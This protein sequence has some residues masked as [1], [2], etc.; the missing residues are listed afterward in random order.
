MIEGL[1]PAQIMPVGRM[2]FSVRGMFCASCAM[3]VQHVIERQPGVKDCT[4]N[5]TSGAALVHW[6]PEEFDLYQLFAR[7]KQL[8][9]EMA[10][11]VDGNEVEQRLQA[12]ANRLQLQLILAG[13]FGMWSM[14][15]TWLLYWDVQGLVGINPLWIGLGAVLFS[16][17]VVLY[18]GLDLYKA[19]WKT[20][21]AG[22]P[23]MDFLVSVGVWGSLLL[24]IWNLWRGH[25]IVYVDAATM[26][27]TFLLLGRLIEIYARKNNLLGIDALRQL[28]PETATLIH[29]GQANQTVPLNEVQVGQL[30]YVQA[31]ERIPVDG[32]VH[33]GQS[34]IDNS[35]LTGES[36]PV[37]VQ[38]G[39]TVYAGM[40]NVLSPLVVRVEQPQ[41]QR[42][43]DTLGLRM[44]ELF[45]AKS[46]MSDAVEA[47]V[48]VLLPAVF[49]VAIVAF[50][51]QLWMNVAIEQAL[52][53]AL[54]L[55]VAACPCAVGLALPLA[56]S[57]GSTKASEAGVL[58]RDPASAEALAKARLFAFDKTGT[59]TTGQLAVTQVVSPFMDEGQLVARAASIEAGVS[60]PVAVAIVN[61]VKQQALELPILTGPIARSFTGVHYEDSDG[62]V[63]LVGAPRWLAEQGVRDV[64]SELPHSEVDVAP[65]AVVHVAQN[66]RWVGA[67]VLHDHIRED[68]LAALNTLR[69]EGCETLLVTG[70]SATAAQWVG[71][72][73]GFASHAIYAAYDPDQKA[74]LLQSYTTVPTAFV[75]D[76]VNDAL[77]LAAADCGVAITGANEI[78]V[79]ASGVV[80]THGGVERVVQARQLAQ[81]TQRRIRQNLFFSV[82][83]NL[84]AVG[85]FFHIGVSPGMAAVAMGLSSFTVVA[86][87]MR[88]F[89]IA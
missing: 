56:F 30:V 8:G 65:A 26:L 49:V 2:I 55:L 62:E 39:S 33:T 14:M 71:Q 72:K 10:P 68:A 25:A 4:V 5:F 59:L 17:P 6:R 64:P 12:Q 89:K 22:V 84:A 27:V 69:D 50:M 76:G 85:I 44:L 74:Q 42:R 86:N 67:L 13:F 43:I 66:H 54:S 15:G 20:L 32:T 57:S 51:R 58:L 35:L 82:C 28:L 34:Q 48:R 79:T 46:S 23:G 52:L 3:S 47:F 37:A 18:S 31:G 40:V 83:Y 60:H 87:S 11:L 1:D 7:I 78:A 61:Y 45:G 73:L 77:V 70:D 63:W 16:L 19:G 29:T 21:R 41:G 53:A 9:Y 81:Q 36:L 88:A 38:A 24:S 75:G 80:I